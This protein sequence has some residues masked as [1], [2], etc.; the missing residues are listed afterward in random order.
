M[1]LVRVM[2]MVMVLAVSFIMAVIRIVR[3]AARKNYTVRTRKEI[4]LILQIEVRRSVTVSIKQK[5]Q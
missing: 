5:S 3:I 2:M 1:V 4:Q